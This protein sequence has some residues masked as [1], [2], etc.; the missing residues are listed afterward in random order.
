MHLFILRVS[1]LENI[2]RFIRVLSKMEYIKIIILADPRWRMLPIMTSLLWIY[3]F[4]IYNQ[5]PWFYQRPYYLSIFRFMSTLSEIW[6]LPINLTIWRHNDARLRH[7]VN[8][9]MPEVGNDEYII[10]HN[11]SI[12]GL[13]GPPVTGSNKSPFWIGLRWHSGTRYITLLHDMCLW[14]VYETNRSV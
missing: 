6:V 7:C 5:L 4:I 14:K 8:Q 3:M 13:R 1:F 11:F 2:S 9:V 10:V 12:G